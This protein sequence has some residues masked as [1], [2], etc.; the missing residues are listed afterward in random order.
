VGLDDR[1][2]G[3]VA[4]GERKVDDETGR[5]EPD[6]NLRLGPEVRLVDALALLHAIGGA[7][8]RQ[9]VYQRVSVSV[10]AGSYNIPGCGHVIRSIRPVSY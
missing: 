9:G 2:V 4:L 5:D 1:L 6:P 3:G 7:S 10:V 8:C